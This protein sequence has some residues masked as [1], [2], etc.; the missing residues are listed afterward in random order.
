MDARPG[1]ARE[2]VERL[3][4]RTYQPPRGMSEEAQAE[5]VADLVDAVRRAL[6]RRG[7]AELLELLERARQWLLEH[8][9]TQTWPT[10][11]EVVRALREVT[12]EG[13]DGGDGWPHRNSEYVIEATARWLRNFG[14]WPGWLDHPVEVAQELVARGEVTESELASAGYRVREYSDGQAAADPLHPRGV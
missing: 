1:A 7:R 10:V 9:P 4:S 5:R 8:H 11:Y 12:G 13:G 14:E 3:T 6:P 2:W